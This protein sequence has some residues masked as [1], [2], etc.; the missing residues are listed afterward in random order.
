MS[1]KKSLS[2]NESTVIFPLHKT[3]C[4]VAL[5]LESCKDISISR[6]H[7]RQDVVKTV[8]LLG[9]AGGFYV[10]KIDSP[11]ARASV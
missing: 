9:A 8:F 7:Y 6:C 4:E 3:T 10:G 5:C 2:I 11:S 1:E